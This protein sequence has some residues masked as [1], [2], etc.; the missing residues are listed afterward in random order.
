MHE[1]LH[2]IL[3]H[4]WSPGQFESSVHKNAHIPA[5]IVRGHLPGF[6]P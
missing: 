4:F 1:L 5:L 2:P 6:G 3:Q